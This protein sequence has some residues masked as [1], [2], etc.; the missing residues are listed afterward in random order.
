MFTLSQASEFTFVGGV[1]T[2]SIFWVVYGHAA[3]LTLASSYNFYELSVSLKKAGMNTIIA[4]AVYAVDVFF[5]LG[6]FF[7]GYLIQVSSPAKIF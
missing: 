3:L 4:A 2:L 7:T 5:Y 6:G 1:R